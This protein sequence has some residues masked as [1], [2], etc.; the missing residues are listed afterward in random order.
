MLIAIE[1]LNIINQWKNTKEYIKEI[2]PKTFYY[3][4][5]YREKHFVIDF[6]PVEFI[7]MINLVSSQIIRLTYLQQQTHCCL[8]VYGI[9]KTYH[10]S[11]TAYEQG[12]IQ[13]I[14][15]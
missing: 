10:F 1:E 2:S 8:N 6:S 3:S 14:Y 12:S 4:K 9:H 11:Y 5:Y 7:A 15:T 13:N